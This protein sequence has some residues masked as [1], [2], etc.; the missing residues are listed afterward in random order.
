M[1][2]QKADEEPTQTLSLRVIAE[3]DPSALPRV[4]SYFQ[5]L[6][7]IPCRV[8]AEREAIESLNIRVEVS[9]LSEERLSIISAKIGQIPGIVNA[10]WQRM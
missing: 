9:G 5:N 10:Y 2:L 6:N 3:L 7:V 1:K 4:L 8:I